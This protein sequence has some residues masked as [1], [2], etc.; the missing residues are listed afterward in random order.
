MS[1]TDQLYTMI[2]FTIIFFV[3]GG[4]ILLSSP[5]IFRMDRR[6]NYCTREKKFIWQKKYKIEIL[7]RLSE[8]KEAIRTG[9][10]FSSSYKLCLKLKSGKD[11]VVFSKPNGRGTS[12]F[13]FDNQAR[14]INDFLCHNEEQY[15]SKQSFYGFVILILFLGGVSL[16]GTIALLFQT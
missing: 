1:T 15:V 6:K 9:G 12:P 5:Y 11:V 16:F 13:D 14:E 3:W 2:F 8:V 10:M 4:Y 7:C